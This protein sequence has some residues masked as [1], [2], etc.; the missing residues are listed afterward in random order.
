[1]NKR[2][3]KE[4][5]NDICDEDCPSD[6][7]CILKEFLISAHPSP[8]LLVQLKCVDRYKKLCENL[9]CKEMSWAEAM[10]LWVKNN[11]AKKFAEVYTE[12]KK[13]LDIYKEVMNNE[14]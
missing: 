7:E 2:Q 12:D 14:G 9:D 11:R 4:L 1:M 13:Y 6:H 5:L 8:R 3:Y 10:D